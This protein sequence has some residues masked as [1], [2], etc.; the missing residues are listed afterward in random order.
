MRN[1]EGESGKRR[2]MGHWRRAGHRVR[3]QQYPRILSD[4][5][6]LWVWFGSLFDIIWGNVE[7]SNV[8]KQCIGLDPDPR[9]SPASVGSGCSSDD[10]DNDDCII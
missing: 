8:G 5:W 1:D 6:T 4:L 10:N 3:C 7:D 9:L 2:T